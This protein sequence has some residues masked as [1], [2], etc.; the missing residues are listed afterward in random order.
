MGNRGATRGKA[1]ASRD[2]SEDVA[3]LDS[4]SRSGGEIQ[5]PRKGVFDEVHFADIR[6]IAGQ[7][8]QRAVA[9]L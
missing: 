8:L 6:A 2:Y 9:N 7:L 4:D 5:P 1:I 3:E